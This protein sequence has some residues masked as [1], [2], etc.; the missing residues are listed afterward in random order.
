MEIRIRRLADK[1]IRMHQHLPDGTNVYFVTDN[2]REFIITCRFHGHGSSLGLAG[3]QGTLH[4]DQPTGTVYR[5]VVAL[6]GACGLNIDDEPVEGLSSWALRGVII[7]E[8]NKKAAEVLL[9]RNND[10]TPTV[11]IDGAIAELKNYL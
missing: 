9:R 3:Q 5:Q 8:Q 10:D 7:A 6:S 4:I 2:G 11:F 1:E